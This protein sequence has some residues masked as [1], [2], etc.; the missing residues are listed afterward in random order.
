MDIFALLRT[1]ASKGASDLHLVVSSPPLLRVNGDLEAVDGTKPLT[2]NEINQAF[3][4]ITTPE[5][6]ESFHHHLELDFNYTLSDVGQLRC[7]AAQQ[8]GAISLAVRL[9][10]A[11]IPT[12]DELELP[13][14]Y[15]GLALK[16]S[17]IFL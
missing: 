4:Q 14:L 9:L 8:R 10:P 12:I 11:K 2:A 1:A 3:L 15:K 7:N 17:P 5:Q 6:R 16:H 13:A